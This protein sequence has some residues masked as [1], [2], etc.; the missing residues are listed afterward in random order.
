MITCWCGNTGLTGFSKDFMKCT[1]CNS[2]VSRKPQSD[3]ESNETS[4]LHNFYGKDYWFSYQE[5]K[6]N[7]P[8][9]LSRARTDLADRCTYWLDTLLKYKLPPASTLE[10]GSA[11]GGFVALLRWANFNATGLEID[12][13]VVDYSSR[14]FSVPILHGRVEDQKIEPAS[15]DVIILMDVLEHLADPVRTMRHCL[16][17]LKQNGILFIQTP[18]LPEN[19]SYKHMEE[20]NDNFLSLLKEI[21]HTYLFNKNAIKKFFHLLGTKYLTFEPAI[22]SHYDM[23]LIA[24]REP[25]QAYSHQEIESKICETPGGRLIQALLDINKK[26]YVLTEKYEESEVDRSERLGVIN[27]LQKK[28]DESEKDRA[29]RLEVINN[30]QKKYDES[31]K[32]RAARLEVIDNLQKKYDESEKDRAARLEVIDKINNKLSIQEGVLNQTNEALSKIEYDLKIKRNELENMFK[33]L[34]D[35]QTSFSWRITKPLRWI[36]SKLI[37]GFSKK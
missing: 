4:G 12:Q 28:Y 18:C 16:T 7:L 25:I 22:F 27:N 14:T 2:L 13:W 10:L 17:L 34:E 8:N 30:L 29:A 1:E 36:H 9:I 32:D 5:N 11:H 33:K 15:L 3:T 31:E 6:L 21:G 35:I 26:N 37:S 19:R 23:C 24:S 20:N